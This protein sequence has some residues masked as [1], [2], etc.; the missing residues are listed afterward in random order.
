[1]APLLILD[2]VCSRRPRC[3]AASSSLPPR[4][5]GEAAPGVAAPSTSWPA[6]ACATGCDTVPP[7]ACPSAASQCSLRKVILARRRLAHGVAGTPAGACSRDDLAPPAGSRATRRPG[8]RPAAS[9][10]RRQHGGR[11]QPPLLAARGRATGGDRLLV[12]SSCGSC[13]SS[14]RPVLQ[15]P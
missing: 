1:M 9:P 4:R 7:T 12:R 5:R 11:T 15:E 10:G 6:L 14:S 8:G 13:R 3:S 2:D